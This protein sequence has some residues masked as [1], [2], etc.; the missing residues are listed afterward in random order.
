MRTGGERGLLFRYCTCSCYR[1]C[2]QCIDGVRRVCAV[3]SR[4]A[5]PSPARIVCPG[6]TKQSSDTIST[7]ASTKPSSSPFIYPSTHP[8]TIHQSTH[9]CPT[10]AMYVSLTHH[11]SNTTT[12]RASRGRASK[13]LPRWAGSVGRSRT[14]GSF[15]PHF[16]R[17]FTPHCRRKAWKWSLSSRRTTLPCRSR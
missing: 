11:R 1:R 2:M 8:P 5:Q 6:R 17:C 16:G 14:C 13:A 15:G 10:D 7:H 4:P 12:C 9:R 3:Q